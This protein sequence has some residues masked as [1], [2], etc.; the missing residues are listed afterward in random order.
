MRQMA[1]EKGEKD[2]TPVVI[3][4]CSVKQE[5]CTHYSVSFGF[6]GMNE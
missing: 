3:T 5:M 1:I 2:H 4:T 6:S